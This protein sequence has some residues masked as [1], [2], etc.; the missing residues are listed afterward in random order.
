M[1][2]SRRMIRETCEV[3]GGDRSC[4]KEEPMIG[5]QPAVNLGV[6]GVSWDG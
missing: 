1:V 5:L 4:R 3:S 2:T 6:Q